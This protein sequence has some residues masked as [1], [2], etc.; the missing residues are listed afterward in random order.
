MEKA[1]HRGAI[2]RLESAVDE[3]IKHIRNLSLKMPQSIMMEK[4]LRG[5]TSEKS[6]IRKKEFFERWEEIE[7]LIKE[8]LGREGD[9]SMRDEFLEIIEKIIS[10]D[11]LN[12][13]KNIKA[14]KEKETAPGATWL[15]GLVDEICREVWA[16]LPNMEIEKGV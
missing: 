11:G 10:R 2:N 4:D 9:L 5:R 8:S 14:L 3:R 1:L 13:I 16:L 7:Q 12:Y 15:M 6:L